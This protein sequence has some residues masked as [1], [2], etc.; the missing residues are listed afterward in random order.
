V[1]QVCTLAEYFV[2]TTCGGT[3]HRLS[4]FATRIVRLAAP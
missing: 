3:R 1:A 2:D 4:N